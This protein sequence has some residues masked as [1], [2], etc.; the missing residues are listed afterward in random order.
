[1]GKSAEDLRQDAAR[2][3][4]QLGETMGAIGDRVSPSRIMERRTNRI[5]DRFQSTRDAVMGR[6][7]DVSETVS[8][9]AGSAGG[10]VEDV[11][12]R[13]GDTFSSLGSTT[14]DAAQGSPL[15]AGLVA[16]GLGFL[17]AAS[18][19]ASKVEMR[20]AGALSDAAEPIKEQVKELAGEAASNLQEPARLAVEE[21]KGAAADAAQSVQES[22]QQAVADVKD[23][24]GT[25]AAAVT[26]AASSQLDDAKVP[27]GPPAER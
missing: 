20:T 17:V 10:A 22:T 16:F 9:F 21:V 8:T 24:A 6:A 15:G 14:R 26:G 5:R 13:V 11:G 23:E 2:Q 12:A 25:A 1:M 7:G 4:A 3:R 27:G 19:P 18:V